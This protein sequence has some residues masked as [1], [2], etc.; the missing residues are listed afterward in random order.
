MT[1]APKDPK[2]MS[3]EDLRAAFPDVKSTPITIGGDG[4]F[5][6]VDNGEL[7]LDEKGN[8]MG[9]PNTETQRAEFVRAREAVEELGGEIARELLESADPSEISRDKVLDRVVGKQPVQQVQQK[10]IG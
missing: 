8:P 10:K 7:L 1:N 2:Q 3:L 9:F 6:R 5:C 4:V